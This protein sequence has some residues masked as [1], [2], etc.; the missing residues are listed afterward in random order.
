MCQTRPLARKTFCCKS[1]RPQLTILTYFNAMAAARLGAD[2]VVNHKEQNV[3][4]VVRDAGGVNLVIELVG[5]T[6]QASIDACANGGRVVLIGNLGG[7]QATVDTQAWRLKLVN[8]LAGGTLHTSTE[9]EERILQLVANKAIQPVIARTMP[10]EEAA[11]AHR[12]LASG[13]VVGKMC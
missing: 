11:E 7:Q 5:T 6:L 1:K 12:I 13:E 3:G 2:M 10:I 8:V 9:N 4:Q